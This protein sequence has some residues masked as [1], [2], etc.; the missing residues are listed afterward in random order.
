MNL[1]VRLN[2]ITSGAH[3][4][5]S[6]SRPTT[7]E[8]RGAFTLVELLV[9]IGII[10]VLIAVLLPAL[11]AA[12]KQANATKCAAHLKQI[13]MAYKLYANDNRDF[14]PPVRWDYPDRGGLYNENPSLQPQNVKNLYWTDML[15]KYVSKFGAMNFQIGS[16]PNAIDAFKQARGSVIWGC[17]EW[18]GY[19]GSGPGYVDGTSIFEGGYS[20]NIYPTYKPN[21]PKLGGT[22]VLSYELHQR[23][24][25]GVIWTYTGRC[26]KQSQFT[27]SAERMLACDATLWLLSFVPTSSPTG[28]LP[29]LVGRQNNSST[30]GNNIDRYRHGKYPQ[31]NGAIY[32]DH[33]GKVAYNILYVDGH[34]STA[35]DIVDGYKA[36][37]MRPP[38]N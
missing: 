6:A 8:S 28:I 5:R 27:M 38:G 15:I 34:V 9:V 16:D 4:K 18:Y 31:P 26:Y 22:A 7:S 13:G 37:R 2:Q 25:P 1:H 30:G 21:Y 14:F 11:S 36:I 35:T 24:G 3:M 20:V 32:P 23:S 17:P 29:Q 12:R 33:N 19:N 10:A